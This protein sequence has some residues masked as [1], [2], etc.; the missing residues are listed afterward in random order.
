MTPAKIDLVI[1]QGST[2]KKEFQWLINDTP[3]DLTGYKFRCQFRLKLKDENVIIELTTE[4]NRI[5]I[6]DAINGLFRLYLTDIETQSFDFNSAVY[7]IEYITPSLEVGRFSEGTV[8]NSLEVT[9]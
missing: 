3:V 8:K 4:N 6:I 5:Q 9:R 2:F 7:D 1:Y